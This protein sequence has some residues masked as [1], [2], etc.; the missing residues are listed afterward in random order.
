MVVE[1]EEM[2]DFKLLQLMNKARSEGLADTQETLTNLGIY[3]M[4][5]GQPHQNLS[6]LPCARV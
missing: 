4:N 1:L 2:E 3:G 6:V 5:A